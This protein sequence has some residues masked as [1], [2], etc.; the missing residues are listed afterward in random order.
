MRIG[1]ARV[2]SQG[3]SL[4]AQIAALTAQGC[5][6]LFEEK[7]SGASRAGRAALR[8]ALDFCREGDVLIV[9][10]LDR[11][12]RSMF[13]LQEIAQ[14]LERK[15]VDLV[16]LDQRI[17]TTTPAGRLTFHL[18]GA[19][20]E[21]ERDLIAARR[22]EGI[23]RAMARGVKFGRR[24]KL[25]PAQARQLRADHA[26]GVPRRTLMAR[27]GISKSTFY[28]LIAEAPSP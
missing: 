25:T 1:Y 3:Q 5:E 12:A 28:R 16:V 7:R 26:Q 24:A 23:A 8:E 6:K 21:F 4:D 27:H 19:V 11:L 17:D 22:S 20:A 18:L 14:G 2:S 10:R 13:D 9:T 15:G